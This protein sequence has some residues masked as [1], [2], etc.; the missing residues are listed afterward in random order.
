MKTL[1]T[2]ALACAFG[3]ASDA[4]TND[5]ATGTETSPYAVLEEMAIWLTSEGKLKLA[6]DC[7]DGPETVEIRTQSQNLY[8]NVIALKYV[9]QRT[10]DHSELGTG[11]LVR[12]KIGRQVTTKAVVTDQVRERSFHLN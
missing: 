4:D 1:M 8:Q 9:V 3:L 5:L 7:Q 2:N 12:L 11:H 6:L 10:L